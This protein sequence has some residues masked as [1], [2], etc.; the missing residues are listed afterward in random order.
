MGPE[1]SPAAQISSS[2]AA[3]SL[4]TFVVSLTF[5]ASSKLGLASIFKRCPACV[6]KGTLAGI[7]SFLLQS[8]ISTAADHP[9][10][11]Q[12]DL[13]WFLHMSSGTLMHCVLGTCLGVSLYITD[14]RCKSPLLF[15]SLF[16]MMVGVANL[17]PL[18]G[19]NQ[20]TRASMESDGWFFSSPAPAGPWYAVYTALDFWEIQ[21][22]PVFSSIPRMVMPSPVPPHYLSSSCKVHIFAP[23]ALL[24]RLLLP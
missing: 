20:V 15:I 17:V 9:L 6:L 12:E 2:L 10:E 13:S 22:T 1:A 4:C 3:I 19:I 18:L 21:W 5:A 14:L 16:F 23:S 24:Q 7:G 8:A 11:T